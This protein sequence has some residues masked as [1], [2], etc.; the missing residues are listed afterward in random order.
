MTIYDTANEQ[1]AGNDAGIRTRVRMVDC[2]ELRYGSR[3]YKV[4]RLYNESE[5]VHLSTHEI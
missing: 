5:S 2:G 4:N 3:L 1:A